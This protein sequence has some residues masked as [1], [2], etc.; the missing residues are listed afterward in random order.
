MSLCRFIILDYTRTTSICAHAVPTSVADVW[1][2]EIYTYIRRGEFALRGYTQAPRTDPFLLYNFFSTLLYLCCWGLPKRVGTPAGIRLLF[3]VWSSS[4]SSL[5]ALWYSSFFLSALSVLFE[6]V[7][8]FGFIWLHVVYRNLLLVATKRHLRI[9]YV[10]N[11]RYRTTASDLLLS[12]WTNGHRPTL[13]VVYL[14]QIAVLP[15]QKHDRN[16]VV[17]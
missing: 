9:G 2:A 14:R 3:T 7:L 4:D 1:C 17:T 13:A 10:S 15:V 8:P 11:H 16:R 5:P 12:V 6:F